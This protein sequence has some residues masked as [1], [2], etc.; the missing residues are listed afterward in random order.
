[1][2]GRGLKQF[3]HEKALLKA[4]SRR[5]A[6]GESR[7]SRETSLY[8]LAACKPPNRVAKTGSLLA[9]HA[10]SQNEWQKI[11]TLVFQIRTCLNIKKQ[12]KH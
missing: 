3:S 11:L 12:S 6:T 9:A 7:V 4:D 5:L 2:V 1:M 8:E 10:S